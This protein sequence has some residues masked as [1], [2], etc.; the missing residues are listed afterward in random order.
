ML[1]ALKGVELD[2]KVTASEL[3]AGFKSNNPDSSRNEEDD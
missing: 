1:G 3:S 2:K